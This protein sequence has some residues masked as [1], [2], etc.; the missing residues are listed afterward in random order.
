MKI[1]VN[2]FL[3]TAQFGPSSFEILPRLREYGFDGFEIPVFDPARVNVRPIRR[4]LVANDLECTI[5][6]ILPPG[7]SAFDGDAQMREKTQKHL[8]HCVELTAEMGATLMSGP[9]YAQVGYLPGRRRTADEW[10]QAIECF[11]GLGPVLDSCGVSLAIEPLNRFETFF[12]NAA[13]D[14]AALCEAI[15]H[16]R[17]GVLLDTFHA[18]IE[19]KSI[20]AAC[21]ELGR[22]LLHVHAC[23][24]DRGI[25]GTGHVDFPAIVDALEEIG[26][27]GYLTIESFGFNL[28]EIASAAAIWRDLAPSPEDI[29]KDGIDYLRRT[30]AARSQR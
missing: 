22:Y 21:R 5:C 9:V 19:E 3:W 12:L 15:G 16:P 1:G 4:A 27:N 17:I 6:A 11:Q 26:Y 13:S 2:A 7:F 20:P 8:A 28:P 14:A 10:N 24:N 30:I 29:A 18:N 23:E 25:P